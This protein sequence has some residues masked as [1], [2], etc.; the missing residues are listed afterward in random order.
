M[1]AAALTMNK[2]LL[3]ALAASGIASVSPALAAQPN[4]HEIWVCNTGNTPQKF[5]IEG[6]KMTRPGFTKELFGRGDDDT[7]QV[8]RNNAYGVVAIES[9]A[10]GV[11]ADNKD[12]K[13]HRGEVSAHV[14]MLQRT[15]GET[16]VLYEWSAALPADGYL[17]A[18]PGSSG[19]CIKV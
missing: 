12:A 1:K 10:R 13:Q 17:V 3:A 11:D 8:L 14:V 2:V 19:S 5:V 4:A 7:L 9:E 16:G 6:D 15:G 18:G